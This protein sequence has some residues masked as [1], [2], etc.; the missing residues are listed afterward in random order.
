M[1][2]ASGMLLCCAEQQLSHVL[3]AEALH[4]DTGALNHK[5]GHACHLAERNNFVSGW[6]IDHDYWAKD[7]HVEYNHQSNAGCQRQTA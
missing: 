4:C 2:P 1:K 7:L 3:Q 5:A 6:S